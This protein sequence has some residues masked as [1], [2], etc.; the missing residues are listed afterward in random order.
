M[1]F[2]DP[3]NWGSALLGVI[4]LILGII[5]LLN[6]F[7][8]IKFGLPGFLS[9][10]ISSIIVYILAITGL[11]LVIDGFMEDDALR[12]ITLVIGLLIFLAGLLEIL[13]KLNVIGFSIPFI[14]NELFINIIFILE[15][16]LLI[17]AAFAMF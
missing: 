15:G 10:I 1:P 6:K 13:K 4:L 9:G 3:K 14:G 11:L 12:V 8:V 7:G 5:P 16:I 17:I 2:D